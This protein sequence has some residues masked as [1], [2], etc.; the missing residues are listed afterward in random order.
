MRGIPAAGTG[1]KAAA[2]TGSAAAPAQ[3][4]T[5]R[6]DAT[7]TWKPYRVAYEAIKALRAVETGATV[8]VLSRDDPGL[9]TDV[10]TWCEAAGHH[11]VASDRPAPGQALSLIRKGEPRRSG[12]SMT[13]IVSTA[14]LEHVVYPLDKAL[15]AAVLGMDVHVVFEGAGVRLLKRGYRPRL[16]GLAGKVF[17][18]MVER[19]MNTQIGWPLAAES[20]AILADLGARFYVCGPSLFGYRVRQ[21]DLAIKDY[22]V[23]AVVTWADL[24]ARTDVH[25]FSKAQFE[26]P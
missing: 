8:E 21:E 11:L 24:L 15:A 6:V 13:V 17:T 7:A 25:V 2:S 19:V 23:G 4:G 26:K 12:R 1:P 14:S 22:T 3:G 18:A 5:P 9:P 16:S 10:A 20:I